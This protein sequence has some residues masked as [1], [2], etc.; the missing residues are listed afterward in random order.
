MIDL[1]NTD[2]MDYKDGCA[3]LH[4]IHKIRV[5]KRNSICVNLLISEIL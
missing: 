3:A 2:F 5:K 4:K 1:F